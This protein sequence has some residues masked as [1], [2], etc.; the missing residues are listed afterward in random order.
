MEKNRPHCTY[1][2]V[3]S[4]IYTD[5]RFWFEAILAQNTNTHFLGGHPV[6]LGDILWNLHENFTG[7]FVYMDVIFC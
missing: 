3:F 4:A 5:L 2:E 1:M 6:F 7:C